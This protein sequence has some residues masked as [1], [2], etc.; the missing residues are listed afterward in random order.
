MGEGLLPARYPTIREILEIG[1]EGEG[2]MKKEIHQVRHGAE[3]C[4]YGNLELSRGGIR[5]K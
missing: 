4:S 3:L 5:N 1:S 2:R